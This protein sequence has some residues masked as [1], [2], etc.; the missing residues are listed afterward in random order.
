MKNESKA[1][2]INPRSCYAALCLLREGQRG[3]GARFF[4]CRIIRR[5]GLE[6]GQ[7]RKQ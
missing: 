4:G 7:K 1:P 3:V 5:T 2:H 6:L